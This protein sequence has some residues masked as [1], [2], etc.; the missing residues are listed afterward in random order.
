ML[1]ILMCGDVAVNPGQVMLGLVNAR[2]I[3]NKGPYLKHIFELLT[4]IFSFVLLPRMGS[5]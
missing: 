5:L 3:R 4:Q 2:S 1:L